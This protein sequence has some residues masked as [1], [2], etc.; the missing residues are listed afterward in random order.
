MLCS[1]KL[2]MIMS[3]LTGLS[4]LRV[5]FCQGKNKIVT[6]VFTIYFGNSRSR[7]YPIENVNHL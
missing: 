7:K 6:P 4:S 5:V 2:Q 1:W 3:V